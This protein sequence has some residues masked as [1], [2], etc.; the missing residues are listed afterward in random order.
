MSCVFG[1][2]GGVLLLVGLLAGSVALVLVA[3]ALGALSLGAA[4]VW[5]GQLIAAWH[6]R[7]DGPSVAPPP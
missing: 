4:L 1:A 7:R 2:V 6:A 5:R 3:T